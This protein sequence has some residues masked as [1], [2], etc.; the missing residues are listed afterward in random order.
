MVS[1]SIL[2]SQPCNLGGVSLKGPPQSP[3]PGVSVRQ[4]QTETYR[5]RAEGWM[6]AAAD[7]LMNGDR[8]WRMF[9]AAGATC[10]KDV[11]C[12]NHTSSHMSSLCVSLL[13]SRILEIVVVCKYR[14]CRTISWFN[15]ESLTG[16][17]PQE[18]GEMRLCETTWL[19][20][21]STWYRCQSWVVVFSCQADG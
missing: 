19:G 18:E 11:T 2:H 5:E 7:R 21:E 20:W 8:S 1:G 17:F 4:R 15:P 12:S 13:S 14:A 10:Q 3:L 6:C 16:F 9:G